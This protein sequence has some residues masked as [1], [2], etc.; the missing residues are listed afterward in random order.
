MLLEQML[1]KLGKVRP[2]TRHK[3]Y[4]VPTHAVLSYN[5][6]SYSVLSCRI[7]SSGEM[8]GDVSKRVRVRRHGGTP[9]T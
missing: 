3:S 4:L 2:L 6:L 1:N 9:H 7:L 5:I 8:G